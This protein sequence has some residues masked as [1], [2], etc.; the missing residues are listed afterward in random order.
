MIGNT[1]WDDLGIDAYETKLD[2]EYRAQ[3]LLE[4]WEKH[5][6]ESDRAKLQQYCQSS[7]NPVEALYA[8]A[9][10]ETLGEDIWYIEK[11]KK[12]WWQL[13]K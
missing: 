4:Y 13:W 6:T 1:F 3:Q 12:R 11:T 8:K 10:L 7:D 2:I 5:L 9:I